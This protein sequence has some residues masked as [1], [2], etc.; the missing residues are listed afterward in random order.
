MSFT[1]DDYLRISDEINISKLGSKIEMILLLNHLQM[2]NYNEDICRD[3]IEELKELAFDV[4]ELKAKATFHNSQEVYDK[5]E[6]YYADIM[7]QLRRMREI[8]NQ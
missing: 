3:K 4:L 5:C 7:F 8:C 6:V 1:Y 2:E